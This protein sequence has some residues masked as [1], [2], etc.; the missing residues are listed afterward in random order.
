MDAKT[1]IT[2]YA[3]PAALVLTSVGTVLTA[4]YL[5]STRNNLAKF[6]STIN[7]KVDADG[8]KRLE[9][10]KSL[11]VAKT[12]LT[13][14][15]TDLN[16]AIS[17]KADTSKVDDLSK[18]LGSISNDQIEKLN[19]NINNNL[20]DI[21]TAISNALKSNKYVTED[22]IEELIKNSQAVK[23]YV[24]G[25]L[26]KVDVIIDNKVSAAKTDLESK[27]NGLNVSELLKTTELSAELKELIKN[28]KLNLVRD[29]NTGEYTLEVVVQ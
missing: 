11:Y 4:G 28:Q 3:I 23:D 22:K 13:T 10:I 12:E 17:A 24:T 6:Q 15:Q 27:I 29:T 18:K 7:A 21:N 1:I 16:N 20:T 19:E 9:Q 2:N 14:L 5:K 26:T 25:E 8:A